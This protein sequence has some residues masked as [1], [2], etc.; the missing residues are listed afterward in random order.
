MLPLRQ[1]QLLTAI[2]VI[3]EYVLEFLTCLTGLNLQ[4]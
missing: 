4:I 1:K 3:K 2:K